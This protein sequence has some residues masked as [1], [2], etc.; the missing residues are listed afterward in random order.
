MATRVLV[1]CRMGRVC[2]W[3]AWVSIPGFI[4]KS[5]PRCAESTCVLLLDAKPSKGRCNDDCRSS[6]RL[7]CRCACGGA[8]H[9]ENLPAETNGV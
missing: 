1:R 2:G 7:K 9:G 8:N 5:C 3:E 4:R 6:E